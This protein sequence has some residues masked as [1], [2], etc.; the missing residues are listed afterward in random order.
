MNGPYLALVLALGSRRW[1]DVPTIH[2]VLLDT[3]HDARQDGYCGIEVLEGGADGADTMSGDWAKAH[4]EDGVGHETLNADWD[5]C[6]PDCKP[7]H[8]RVRRNGTSYCP[9]AGHRRNQ[10]MVDRGPL[11]AV[12]F[13]RAG[14]TGTADCIRRAKAAGIPV[15]EV[16]AA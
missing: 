2:D 10:Q 4:L 16:A 5:H 15:R 6:A 1:T 3:W 13:N 8:R 12:A 14:S 9:T 11:I 7:V